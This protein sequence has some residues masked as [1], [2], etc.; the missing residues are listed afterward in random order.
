MAVIRLYQNTVRKIIIF[1]LFAI[2]AL[3][4]SCGGGFQSDNKNA[5][6]FIKTIFHPEEIETDTTDNK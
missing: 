3:Y 6:T 1:L 2:F 5:D 4:L